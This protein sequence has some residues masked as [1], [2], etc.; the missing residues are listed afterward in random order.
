MKLLNYKVNNNNEVQ[1]GVLI[2]DYIVSF[3]TLQNKF[4]KKY[5]ELN[6]IDA[7]LNNLPESENLARELFLKGEERILNFKST[8]KI[9]LTHVKILPPVLSPPALLDFGMSPR[10]LINSF[11]TMAKYEIIWPLNYLI[12]FIVKSINP[13]LDAKMRYY[14]CN[15][16]SIIGDMDSPVWPRFSSYLDIEP[17]LG[18]VVG[19]ASYNMSE[20]ELRKSIAGYLIYNDFSARDIQW[21]EMLGLA[22]PARCKDFERGNGIGPF[23]VTVDEINDPLALSVEVKLG[24]RFIWE[25]STSEYSTHPIELIR[26]LTGFQSLAP[27]T[28]IGMGTIPGCCC[29]ENDQWLLPGEQIEISMRGLGRLRQII[30]SDIG[31]IEETGWKKRPELLK[32]M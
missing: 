17:E 19:K 1:F 28:I 11:L 31:E 25:G 14:K 23:L 2:D 27:G 5:S 22:G 18:I 16:N 10:H 26:Y 4:K 13:K 6:D 12:R 30:P 8:E 9:S 7:Y 32:F 15:H 20:E 21:S 29:L 24:D 3:K